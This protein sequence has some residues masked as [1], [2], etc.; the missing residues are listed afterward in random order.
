MPIHSTLP[1][2]PSRLLHIFLTPLNSL[3][4]HLQSEF[5][6]NYGAQNST[7]SLTNYVKD[8]RGIILYILYRTFAPQNHFIFL[9]HANTWKVQ[10]AFLT[11]LIIKIQRWSF[12]TNSGFRHRHTIR[13]LRPESFKLFYFIAWYVYSMLVNQKLP[14]I[15]SNSGRIVL[16]N[17]LDTSSV[18]VLTY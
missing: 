3:L 1:P 6:L 5:L 18:N 11:K 14:L 15:Y 12:L 10:W 13:V 7:L 17:A 16:F 2:A 9:K 4:D 8:N